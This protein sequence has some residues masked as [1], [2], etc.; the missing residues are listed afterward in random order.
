M[1]VQCV[2]VQCD[3]GTVCVPIELL[4][5]SSTQGDV[6]PVCPHG[7]IINLHFNLRNPVCWY[8]VSPWSYCQSGSNK[9]DDGP[10]CVAIKLEPKA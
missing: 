8:S 2:P 5:T 7:A 1:L 4:S 3:V 6:D 9:Y 10:A